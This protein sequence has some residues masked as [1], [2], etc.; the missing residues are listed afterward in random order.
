MKIQLFTIAIAA[1]TLYGC[2][3]TQNKEIMNGDNTNDEK[4]ITETKWVL[5]TLEGKKIDTP[6]S[7][8]EISFTMD[9]KE[10]RISGY[11]GCNRF[12]GNFKLEDGNRINFSAL[13]ATK[14]ACPDKAFNES[15]FLEI[16]GL[17]DNYTITGNILSLN[18]GKR[19]P[20]ATFRKL[21]NKSETITEKYWKL[22]TLEGQNVVMSKNQ[23]KE[24]YFML[25]TDDNR[26][27][28]FAGCNTMMGSYTLEEGNRIRFSQ[29]AT[30]LMACP[31]VNVNE[32]EFLKI[33]E[34][35]DNYTINGDT[36]SLNVGRRAPLAVFEAV[37]F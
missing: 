36:L 35:A 19:A 9:A 15:E 28:G 4:T 7:G 37:Y 10:N 27:T 20:L 8:E 6:K 11:S 16:F 14:M 22:K 17:A 30:T 3:T 21:E 29:M 32:A 2:G 31:D 26:V 23:A 25:K 24:I 18:V 13:G 5:E 12:F 33:F 34:L 1:L